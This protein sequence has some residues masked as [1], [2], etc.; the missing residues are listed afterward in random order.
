MR[1]T[2]GGPSGLTPHAVQIRGTEISPPRRACGP[3]ARPAWSGGRA[4]GI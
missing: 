3:G 4:R 1:P 2:L